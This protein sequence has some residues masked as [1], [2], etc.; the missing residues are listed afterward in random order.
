MF[1]L[2]V[3][4][5]C[6][7]NI[8]F[9]AISFV[10]NYAIKLWVI[11]TIGQKYGIKFILNCFVGQQPANKFPVIETELM[12]TNIVMVFVTYFEKHWLAR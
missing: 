1:H 9:S 2:E 8:M 12:H 7:V 11:W 3:T 10:V 6:I 5:F 4:K